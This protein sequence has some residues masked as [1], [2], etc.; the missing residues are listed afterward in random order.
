M[1]DQWEQDGVKPIVYLNPYLANTNEFGVKS[2]LF[3]EALL[4]DY[5][6]KTK[7]GK[8][9]QVQ[10][11]SIKM[12]LIDLTNPD[13]RVWV[14][15]KII[16]N[17]IL[18]VARAGGWMHDFGEYLPFDAVLFDKS[19]PIEYH[20][21]YVEDWAKLANEAVA[22]MGLEQDVFYFMRAGAARSPQNTSVFWMGD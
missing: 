13:A 2:E 20:E 4:N 21:R 22:E 17:N 11:V 9:Y 16:N 3:S 15:E 12:G 14:K 6:V 1:V 10:S 19:D 5:F 18:K 7:K 8:P